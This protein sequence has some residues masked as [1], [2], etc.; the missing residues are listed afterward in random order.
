MEE[1]KIRRSY[2][3]IPLPDTFIH[4]NLQARQIQ[5]KQYT[6]KP[7]VKLLRSK[8]LV[9]GSLPLKLRFKRM[10]D[11]VK[12]WSKDFKNA[13][14]VWTS[15]QPHNKLWDVVEEVVDYYTAYTKNSNLRTKKELLDHKLCTLYIQYEQFIYYC[16]EKQYL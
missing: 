7:T 5:Y 8:G 2:K 16:N 6:T 14:T 4:R 1:E 3:A 10:Y 13:E 15:P 11:K 12:G 9:E